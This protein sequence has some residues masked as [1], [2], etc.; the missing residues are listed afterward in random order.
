VNDNDDAD[1]LAFLVVAVFPFDS[2]NKDLLVPRLPRLPPGFTFCFSALG[3]SLA[4]VRS[5]SC[6]PNK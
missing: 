1:S 6:T 2:H 3:R 4:T 5:L